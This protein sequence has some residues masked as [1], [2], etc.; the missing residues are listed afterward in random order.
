MDI[1][2]PPPVAAAAAAAVFES[3]NELSHSVLLRTC[4]FFSN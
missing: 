4:G 2:Y 3:L 1:F